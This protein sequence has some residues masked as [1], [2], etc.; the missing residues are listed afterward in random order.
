VVKSHRLIWQADEL[1]PKLNTKSNADSAIDVSGDFNFEAPQATT[2]KEEDKAA[3][4]TSD[5][6]E[7]T[8]EIPAIPFSLKD[9]RLSV[10]R[11]KEHFGRT[12][13]ISDI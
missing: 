13:M 12:I 11:G 8:E 6:D 1:H 2:G 9:I 7:K 5:A 4:P 10:P 3:K